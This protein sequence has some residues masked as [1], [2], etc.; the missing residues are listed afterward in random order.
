[1]TE[2]QS[3]LK[4]TKLFV[5]QYILTLS[6]AFCAQYL[7]MQIRGNDSGVHLVRVC[8]AN[9]TLHTVHCDMSCCGVML[10]LHYCWLHVICTLHMYYGCT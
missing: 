10:V 4:G 5:V 9:D 1:M 7:R 3:E 2:L 6:T 8:V